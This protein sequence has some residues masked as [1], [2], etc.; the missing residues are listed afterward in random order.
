MTEGS[1]REMRKKKEMDVIHERKEEKGKD[2]K[3]V[4]EGSR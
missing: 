3:G 1:K 2:G 4:E